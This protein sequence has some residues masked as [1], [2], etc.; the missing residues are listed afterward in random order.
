MRTRDR[1]EVAGAN[2]RADL[3]G[4]KLEMVPHVEEFST[5]LEVASP[6]FAEHEVLEEGHVPIVTS[7]AAY[8]VAR[9]IAPR[10]CRGRRVDRGV[11]PFT[12]GV[13]VVRRAGYVWPIAAVR[14]LT[15]YVRAAYAKIDRNAV[16]GA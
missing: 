3:G 5:Q 8:A 7:R 4:I 12:N 16:I 10:A 15:A 13:W 1:A 14:N 11:E 2:A 6:R 9:G